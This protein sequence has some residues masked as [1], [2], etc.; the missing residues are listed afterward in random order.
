M[1]HEFTF[2]CPVH[3]STA[4]V[5]GT[6]DQTDIDEYAGIINRETWDA[7]LPGCSNECK[8]DLDLLIYDGYLESSKRYLVMSK[9][10]ENVELLIY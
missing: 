1:T 5:R 10:D 6:V 3:N 4:I 9:E 8:I 2:H 7:M